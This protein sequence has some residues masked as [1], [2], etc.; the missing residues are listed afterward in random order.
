MIQRHPQTI[1]PSCSFEMTSFLGR[2][3]ISVSCDSP[4]I[5]TPCS[6]WISV[7]GTSIKSNH[8]WQAQAGQ[9]PKLLNFALRGGASAKVQIPRKSTVH[10]S[11][12]MSFFVNRLF[13]RF[14]ISSVASR[15]FQRLLWLSILVM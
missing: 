4:L 10:I 14:C 8:G 2:C 7:P 15:W 9:R 5:A 3:S 12:Q 13:E 6:A 11:C 1:S